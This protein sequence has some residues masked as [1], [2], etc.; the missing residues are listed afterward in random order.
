M[1]LLVI[2]CMECAHGARVRSVLWLPAVLQPASCRTPQ[3]AWHS[4]IGLHSD[5]GHLTCCMQIL[6]M[7]YLLHSL[8]SRSLVKAC[9][10]ST[11]SGAAS[12][13]GCS[14]ARHELSS[15]GSSTAG[16]PFCCSWRHGLQGTTCIIFCST[17]LSSSAACMRL[18][19]RSN[20]R[21][22]AQRQSSN[23]CRTACYV[24]QRHQVVATSVVAR[25]CS[26][27]IEVTCMCYMSCFASSLR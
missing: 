16:G 21:C 9:R 20:D 1:P 27:P 11:S 13:Q 19:A 14:W 22:M 23:S 8:A 7:V 5:L 4:S 17:N 24:W 18:T 2:L 25:L 3:H 6:C 10:K 12:Q 15:P 26:S